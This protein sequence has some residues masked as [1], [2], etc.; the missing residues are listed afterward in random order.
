MIDAN[1]FPGLD[2]YVKSESEATEWHLLRR[3]P[4]HWF[5]KDQWDALRDQV[6]REQITPA[7]AAA[8]LSQR[9]LDEFEAQGLNV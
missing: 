8:Q 5:V 2:F 3:C 7:E 1:A 4:I 9:A 6:A